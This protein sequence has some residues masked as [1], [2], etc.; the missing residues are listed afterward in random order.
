MKP[1]HVIRAVRAATGIVLLLG[2]ISYA[3]HAAAAE[4]TLTKV[5]EGIYSYADTRNASPQNSFGANAG[6]VVGREGILVVDTLVSAKEA[7]RF[8]KDIR[9]VSD[10]PIKYVV[11]THS[12]LDHAFGN[13]EFAKLGAVIISHSNCRKDLEAR[14]EETL[15]RAAGYGLAADDL[16]GTVITLPSITFSER[17]EIDLGGLRV[18]LIYPGPSHTDGSILVS[19]P[20]RRVLFAGDALFTGYHPNLAEGDLDSWIKALDY[21]SALGAVS[22]IPGHGPLS[23]KK[24]VEDMKDYLRVFDG[25]ARELA[26]NSDDPA[27]IVS[28]LKKA[29]PGRT[30]LEFLIG[31]N[32]QARYIRKDGRKER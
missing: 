23:G 15:K 17:M 14:G 22:I 13:S 3:A 32:V 8:I 21:I 25:R 27:F 20:E 9:T 6:I 5:A 30:E 11:N 31:A 10:K 16:A 7:A 18:E 2:I 26:A 29:L 24:D 19:V 12:H 1:S 28:E 4:Q